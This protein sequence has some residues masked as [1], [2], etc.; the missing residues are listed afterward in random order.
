MTHSDTAGAGPHVLRKEGRIEKRIA[1]ARDWSNAEIVGRT[2]TIDR[3][4]AEIYAFWRDFQ[5]L[6]RFMENI[7]RVDVLDAKR[8]HWVV[9]APGDD[10][11]EWDAIITEERDNELIAWKSAEDA[12]IKH[13]GRVEFRDGPP[14]RGT[15]IK[16]VLAYEAPGGGAGKLI[17]KLSQKE[18]QIQARRDLRRLKQLL[19]TGE[20]STTHTPA[21]A[22]RAKH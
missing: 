11:V 15:E 2:I 17:A 6:A 1:E 20:I 22:P 14:G 7:Q 10:S 4:R 5:N 8:S 19:E 21:A 9:S 18:P 3:P 13:L 12:D 16:V